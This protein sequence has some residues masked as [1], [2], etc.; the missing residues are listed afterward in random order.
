MNENTAPAVEEISAD[1]VDVFD[2]WD[3][4]G[5][6]EADQP[7]PEQSEQPAEESEQD[8][9]QD[10]PQSGDDP[11]AEEPKQEQDDAVFLTLKHLDEVRTVTR[12]EAQE[13][14]Q[15]GLD[16]DRVQAERNELRAYKQ[17]NSAAIDLVQKYAD[18]NNMSI[19]EYLE[20]C[21]VQEL[22]SDGNLSEDAAK[23]QVALEKREMDITRREEAQ[24]ERERAESEAKQAGDNEQERIRRE[25]S[26]FL[27]DYPDVK[28]GDVPPEVFE[29]VQR[30]KTSLSVAYGKWLLDQQSKELEALKA[31]ENARKKSPGSLSGSLKTPPVDPAFDGWD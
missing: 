12:Q 9:A 2:G 18:R 11:E 19:P 13:L 5:T 7:K 15:K 31:Q 26:Q 22:M 25:V 17:A 23:S 6:M 28:P 14:A 4:E 27:A 3:T 30:D 10:A 8:E 29:A 24:A 16:Y 21:R 1:Q 20:F